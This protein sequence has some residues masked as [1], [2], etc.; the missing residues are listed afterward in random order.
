MCCDIMSLEDLYDE[1]PEMGHTHH[2]NEV[3]LCQQKI[4]LDPF[5]GATL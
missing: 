3:H 5:L 4:T 2:V 1:G